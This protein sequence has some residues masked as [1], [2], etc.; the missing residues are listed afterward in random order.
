MSR[1]LIHDPNASPDECL[2]LPASTKEEVI[3]C[4]DHEALVGALGY[5]R[6]DVLVYVI[7]DLADDLQWLTHLR[8]VAPTLPIILLGGATD[9]T[10]RRKFQELKPTYYGVLPLE[11]FELRDAVRGALQ[12]GV[13]RG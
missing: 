12:R 5:Q 4:K 10:S 7:K 6:P 11:R 9:L 8:R 2:S 13:P 3:T 1:I